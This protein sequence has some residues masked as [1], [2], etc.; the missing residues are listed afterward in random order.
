VFLPTLV[1]AVP[2]LVL[3]KGGDALSVCF[4]TIAILFLTEVICTKFTHTHSNCE[5]PNPNLCHAYGPVPQIDNAAY[6][7]G[8]SERVRTRVEEF[9]RVELRDTEAAAL[10]RSKTV[11]VMLVVVTVPAAVWSE[12]FGW[13]QALVPF[14]VFWLGGVAEAVATPGAGAAEKVTG[15][16]K[17]TAAAALGVVCF[18]G[19]IM[20][21][22]GV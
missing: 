16:G 4:N 2:A 11:H 22:F 14:L 12:D 5:M 6:A 7:V 9:G 15:V 17:A 10:V 20:L 3:V 1:G 18:T 21:A 13:A 19:M 8:L